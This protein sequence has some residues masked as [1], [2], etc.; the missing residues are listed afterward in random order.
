MNKKREWIS[1][2]ILVVMIYMMIGYIYGLAFVLRDEECGISKANASI[3]NV[4]LW[5]GNHLIRE[6][7]YCE[8]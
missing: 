5:P 6:D 7:W 8:D 2:L 1:L 4:F 3:Q